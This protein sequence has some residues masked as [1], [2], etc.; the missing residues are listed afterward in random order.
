MAT[1]NAFRDHGIDREVA[2]GQRLGLYNY[3]DSD[4]L[5]DA[6]ASGE[7]VS[8]KPQGGDFWVLHAEIGI[9]ASPANR[10]LFKTARPDVLDFLRGTTAA[11]HDAFPRAQKP[12]VTSAVRTEQYADNLRA[13]GNPNVAKGYTSSHLLGTTLDVSYRLMTASERA[14]WEDRLKV[15]E[16]AGEIEATRETQQPVYH[17]MVLKQREA[18]A[19]APAPAPAPA[20][21]VA[22]QSALSAPPTS[23][24][25]WWI[26]GGVV[27]VGLG[28]LI[29]GL[30]RRH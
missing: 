29:Y 22:P 12:V 13:S 30:R 28:A 9:H 11:F 23:A 10:D 15:A 18:V 3:H 16:D 17:F 5:R 7:L 1:L 8:I 6:V 19:E 20:P 24:A 25:R 4:A 14:W 21:P 26:G 2:A 27:A